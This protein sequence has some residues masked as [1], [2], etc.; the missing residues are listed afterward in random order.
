M[1]PFLFYYIG[2]GN[3]SPNIGREEFFMTDTKINVSCSLP[4]M[5]TIKETA[6]ITG[7]H[8][9][10]IRRL[11]KQNRIVYI[12]AGRKTLVNLDKFIEYLNKGENEHIENIS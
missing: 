3:A 12:T 8:E 5:R 4:R 11:V 6:Q 10:H 1:F 2:I 9:Y 7:L